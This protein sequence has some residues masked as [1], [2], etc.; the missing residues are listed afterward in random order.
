MVNNSYAR[1]PHP[2]S[3]GPRALVDATA[4]ADVLLALTFVVAAFELNPGRR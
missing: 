4:A 1:G 2:R 3:L